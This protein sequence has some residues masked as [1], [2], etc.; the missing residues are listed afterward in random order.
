MDKVTR[1]LDA[2]RSSH[3]DI[4][5][6]YMEGRCFDLF[7][8]L[9]TLWPDAQPYH[10]HSEGHIYTKLDDRFYDIRG[11][12]YRLPSDLGPLNYREGHAPHRWATG[13]HRRLIHPKEIT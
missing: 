10:S 4:E 2:L 12:R 5:A 6:L 8:I 1:F 7:M 13:D 3:P 11:R 9:R